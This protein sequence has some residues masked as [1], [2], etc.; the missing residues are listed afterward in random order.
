MKKFNLPLTL[1]LPLLF[2][3]VL[4]SESSSLIQT[5]I[6]TAVTPSL[7]LGSKAAR[8]IL[9]CFPQYSWVF[10]R[11]LF[12]ILKHT[13]TSSPPPSLSARHSY[14][15]LH[16][17]IRLQRFATDT[18]LLLFVF[19]AGEIS[20]CILWGSV[21]YGNHKCVWFVFGNLVES[22]SSVLRRLTLLW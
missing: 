13:T 16:R 8:K 1:F 14:S 5:S 19:K 12:N 17:S 20:F 22:R 11:M 6:S 2:S 7:E 18:L 21:L 15:F 10:R 9:S 3:S 4:C